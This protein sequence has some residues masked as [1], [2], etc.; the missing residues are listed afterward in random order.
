MFVCFEK[1]IYYKYC[2]PWLF[3]F[4]IL[5]KFGHPSPVPSFLVGCK[6]QHRGHWAA[7][8]YPPGKGA[9]W[10]RAGEAAEPRGFFWRHKKEAGW[11]WGE[12]GAASPRWTEPGPGMA[13]WEWQWPA[14]GCA[15]GE[16][17]QGHLLLMSDQTAVPSANIF[18]IREAWKRFP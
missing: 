3:P 1:R 16:D 2:V 12:Q 6:S 10:A 14:F 17:L 4:T 11:S 13:T 5:N 9:S 18:E 15:T 7:A 8:E